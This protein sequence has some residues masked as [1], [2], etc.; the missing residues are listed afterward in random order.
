MA[1][2]PE[3][4]PSGPVTAPSK[5]LSLSNDVAGDAG[6][7]SHATGN[8]SIVPFVEPVNGSG[9]TRASA[10]DD[11]ND[12]AYITGVKL[13]IILIALC[14][15]NFL[16]A[17]DT[18]IISTAIPVISQDFH[19]LQD[20]GWYISAYFLTN[21][22]FQ[23]FY[24]KLYALYNV[25]VI[26]IGAMAIFEI[27][28]LI[29]AVAP[30]SPVFILG[31]AV[32]GVGSAGTFSGALIAIIHAVPPEKRAGYSGMIVGMY[33]IA[34]VAGPL[35]GGAFTTH[36]SWRWCFYINLPVGGV[37]IVGMLFFL[38]SPKAANNNNNN[39]PSIR[40][41][42]LWPRIAKFDPFGTVFFLASI[43]CLLLALKLGGTTYAFSDGRVVALFV[44]FGVLLLA[45]LA[46]QFWGGA[47][48]TV[49]PRVLRQRSIIF[50]A[51]Y[52]FCVGSHFFVL[53]YFLPIWFQ[54]VLGRTALQS[55]I[56]TLPILLA[57]TLCVVAG[58]VIVSAT[59]LY[60]VLM[61]ASAVLAPIGAGLLTTL[62]VDSGAGKWIGYQVLYGIGGGLGYQQGVTAAQTVLGPEDAAIGTALM[63]FVQNLGG[64]IF[65]SA[66]NNVFDTKLVDELAR[67]VPSLDPQAILDAG[68]TGIRAVV[69]AAEYPLVLVAYNKAVTTT[70]LMGLILACLCSI[71]AAGMELKRAKTKEKENKLTEAEE[72]QQAREG[73]TEKQDAENVSPGENPAAI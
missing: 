47:N 50:G 34:S 62:Q 32:A 69:T 42:G 4:N 9:V 28:S 39:N 13:A 44:V 36:V 40:P 55:G 54:G 45:F 8:P 48:A 38:R 35:I 29:C 33:G 31:R 17:L 71:G 73:Q 60:L 27:G 70:F 14:M 18:T 67:S 24:G 11:D 63:V 41:A 23:L 51:F 46:L 52:M 12:N 25:K 65:T 43:I 49:P 16:V 53:V 3:Q 59:G 61:W 26:I 15:A 2:S 6:H 19:T 5:S 37:A 68:A 66:A 64:A 58:G 30:S 56:D 20:V 1:A 10:D 21:C 57:E 7:G 22:T 72:A